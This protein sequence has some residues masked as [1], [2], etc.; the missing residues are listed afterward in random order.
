MA[1]PK[2]RPPESLEKRVMAFLANR[3]GAENIDRLPLT[4]A[5]RASEKADFFLE[6][7]TIVCEVKALQTDTKEKI[8]RILEPILQRSDAPVFYGEWEMEKVLKNLPDGEAIR[9]KVFEATTSAIWNLFRKANEQ[10]KAT[11]GTFDLPSAGGVL[12]LANDLV[13]ILSPQVLVARVNELFGHKEPDGRISYPEVE[14]VW[15]LAETHLVDIGQGQQSVAAITI[16]REDDSAAVRCLDALQRP[17]AAV[18]GM[19]YVEMKQDLFSTL[20]FQEIP[21]SPP[22]THGPRHERWRLEYRRNPYLRH[23]SE[24]QLKEFFAKL[25]PAMT[26]GFLKGAKPGQLETASA[27]MEQFTHFLEELRARG[28]DFRKITGGLPPMG[29]DLPPVA[30][31]PGLAATVH[32]APKFERDRFYTNRE[33]KHYRCL[34]VSGDNVWLLLLDLVAGRS[35]EV[36]MRTKMATAAHYHPVFDPGLLAGLETRYIRWAVRHRAKFDAEHPQ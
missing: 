35:L 13:P 16:H 6:R 5:Q 28:L 9:R 30:D 24:V 10:I 27:L 25:M 33:G 1:D 36:T 11:K 17:W 4:P 3:P 29:P 34:T 18:H 7:R 8:D 22:P 31:L 23:H 32:V 12:V 20:Q 15:I 19:P 14:A 2:T 26:V 21:K